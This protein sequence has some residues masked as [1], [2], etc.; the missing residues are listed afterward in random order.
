MTTNTHNV[1]EG[2]CGRN[3]N[4]YWFNFQ[5]IVNLISKFLSN[6]DTKST[7]GIVFWYKVDKEPM[8][9]QFV[10]V[11]MFN[12]ILEKQRE[13][14]QSL[15][16]ITEITGKIDALSNKIDEIQQRM[17]KWGRMWEEW[18]HD[19]EW[20]QQRPESTNVEL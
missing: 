15:D 5:L 14:E 13:Q 7:Q 9:Q 20:Q 3:D 11:K 17:S 16:D 8:E 4:K 18:I 2:E 19:C 12:D 6:C 1:N 10:T